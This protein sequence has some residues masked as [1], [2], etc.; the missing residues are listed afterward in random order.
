M[1]AKIYALSA[2]AA[3]ALTAT[4]AAMEPGFPRGEKLFQ[5]VDADH[6]GK[7]SLAEI[8]PGLAKRFQ[9]V[10]KDKDGAVT[11]AEIDA[12]LT[13]EIEQR[14]ARIL[15]RMD[16]DKDGAVSR[17]ELDRLVETLFNDADQDHDGGVT[18]AEARA[19]RAVKRGK[20][21]QETQPN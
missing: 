10:D 18:L 9:R 7:L 15:A 12:W 1:T 3:L 19:F 5:R 4:A 2:L 17:N 14:K 16:A 11:S 20:A 6:D 8:K 21:V 13:R